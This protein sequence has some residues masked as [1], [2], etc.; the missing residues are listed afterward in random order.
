VLDRYY[1]ALLL[2]AA[3]ELR[4]GSQD[5]AIAK[6]LD[7]RDTMDGHPVMLSWYWRIPLRLQLVEAYLS[8][9]DLSQARQQAD[10]TLEA[11]LQ[12]AERAWQARAWDAS[13]RVALHE[14]DV[15]RAA[16]DIQNA[17]DI[18]QGQTLPLAAW[19]VHK[20]AAQLSRINGDTQSY[21][22]HLT[23][24]RQIVRALTQS[25]DSR[26]ALK[27]IFQS[28]P[29]ISELSRDDEQALSASK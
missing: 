25:L 11:S 20:T 12:T 27:E 17:L 2:E 8:Q 23:A 1:Q 6:L 5:G 19:R 18:M 4:L 22:S 29:E 16:K 28:S 7:L 21:A 9:R 3:A 14:G 26:P 13:A 10:S 24:A 15:P